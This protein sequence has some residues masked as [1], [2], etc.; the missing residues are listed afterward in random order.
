MWK[1]IFE[2]RYLGEAAEVVN[3]VSQYVPNLK[4]RFSNAL[5]SSR[6]GNIS[7]QLLE[8]VIFHGF[9]QQNNDEIKKYPSFDACLNVQLKECSIYNHEIA[10]QYW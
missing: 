7:K 2:S 9:Q 5:F 3:V 1:A 4:E 8:S 10:D 6:I